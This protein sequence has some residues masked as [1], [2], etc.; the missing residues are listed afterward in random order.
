MEKWQTES[1]TAGAAEKQS[2]AM[3]AWGMSAH[4]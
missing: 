1:I 3:E 2:W 4:T